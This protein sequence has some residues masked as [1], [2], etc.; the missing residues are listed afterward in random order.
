VVV[1]VAESLNRVLMKMGRCA[2]YCDDNKKRNDFK[3]SCAEEIA[4]NMEAVV[5][6]S[7]MRCRN[8]ILKAEGGGGGSCTACTKRIPQDGSIR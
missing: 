8:Q 4:Q 5:R 3:Q 7:V 2:R 6:C 1:K